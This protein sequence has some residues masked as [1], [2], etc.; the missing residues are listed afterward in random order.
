MTLMESIAS[1]HDTTILHPKFILATIEI[2]IMCGGTEIVNT[3][4]EKC[5]QNNLLAEARV[6]EFISQLN[7]ESRLLEIVFLT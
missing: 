4:L 7:I 5:A 6:E 2:E 3:Y 1:F